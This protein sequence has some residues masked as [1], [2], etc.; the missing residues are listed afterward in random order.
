MATITANITIPDSV[1]YS[2]NDAISNSNTVPVTGMFTGVTKAVGG[3]GAITDA[4]IITSA[5][6]S[7]PLQGEIWVFDQAVAPAK[8]NQ[9]F[10]VSD[11]D[12]KKLVGVIPFNL[13]DSGSNGAASVKT[14]LGFTCVA[15]MDLWFLVRARNSYTPVTGETLTIRIKTMSVE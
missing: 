6:A 10:V 15:S 12:I 9:P 3:S 1:R 8:N 13:T 14:L 11:S 4:V 2:V 7:I 5:D